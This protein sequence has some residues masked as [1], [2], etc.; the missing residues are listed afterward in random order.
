MTL[1]LDADTGTQDLLL[2]PV[3][4]DVLNWRSGISPADPDTSRQRAVALAWTS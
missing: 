4:A 3:M 1:Q 2:L